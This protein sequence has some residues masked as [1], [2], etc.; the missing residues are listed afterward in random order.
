MF[1]KITSLCTMQ[2]CGSI[3][4]HVHSGAYDVCGTGPAQSK[5]PEDWQNCCPKHVE[6]N[7]IYQ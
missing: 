4:C 6:L 1:G 2:W 3:L 5:A 7:W